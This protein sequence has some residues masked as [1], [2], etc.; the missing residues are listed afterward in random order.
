MASPES[1]F[2]LAQLCELAEV[3]P[4]TVRYYIQQGLLPS[5]GT[6]GPMARYDQSHV[7]RIRLIKRLQRE[8][9]PLAE[10]RQQLEALDGAGV[11][12]ALDAPPK[13]Q[14]AALAYLRSV[15]PLPLPEATRAITARSAEPT[16]GA[17]GD[18]QAPGSAAHTPIIPHR[19]QWDRIPLA[20]DVELHIRRPLSREQN[21]LVDRLIEAARQIFQEIKP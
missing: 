20:P 13:P 21:R 18:Q 16:R 10:I 9:L 1:A 19:S 4:R 5:P 14:S 8:H 3:T 12:R 15:L 11:Q 7:D 2:D 17:H 6:R